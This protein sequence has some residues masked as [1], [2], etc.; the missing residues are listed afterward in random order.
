MDSAG[1]L[2]PHYT[3]RHMRGGDTDAYC[4]R[5]WYYFDISH[6]G[7]N[8]HLRLCMTLSGLEDDPERGLSKATQKR[9]LMPWGDVRNLHSLTVEGPHDD[10]IVEDLR[11]AMEE[12]YP[13]PAD[14]LERCDA[15]KDAGNAAFKASKWELALEQYV[16]AFEAIHIIVDGQR[17][18]IWAEAYFY[19]TLP[20]GKWRGHYGGNIYM[21][22]RI[23]LLANIMA[24]Y[25]KMEQYSMVLFWG[26]RS[27]D[28][29]RQ[30]RP[31]DEPHPAFPIEMGKVYWRTALAAR[32]LN[33]MT[34]AR[35]MIR[36]AAKWL[37]NNIQ[38]QRDRA[39]WGNLQ[40]G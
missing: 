12:E 19:G 3:L 24:V 10:I 28:M 16:K 13:T 1:E 7:L 31:D 26:K 2:R 17:R 9:L 38:V 18:H 8:G 20:T 37:P 14:C 11:K 25:L 5:M 30:G 35:E 22:L 29:F 6:D 27:I 36:V 40:L 23:K 15:F 21:D 39:E 33:D 4:S 34:T 32:A